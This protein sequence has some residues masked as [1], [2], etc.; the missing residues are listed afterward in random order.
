LDTLSNIQNV[1]GSTYSDILTGD[2]S[3]NIFVG[4][5]GDDTI[6]GG[7]G[8][9]TVDCS[10][11]IAG[12]TV[13]LSG[14]TATDGWGGTDTLTNI[15][16]V[17]GS[18]FDDMITP[19]LFYDNV[20]DGGGG[21]NTV[22]FYY[23]PSGVTVDLHDGTATGAGNDTLINIQNVIG[24]FYDDTFISNSGNHVFDGGAGV[25]T[26]SY[27]YANSG[28]TIDLTAGTATGDGSD[29]LIGIYNATGSSHNDVFVGIS[30][31]DNIIDGGGGIN[32]IDYSHDFAAVTVLL[33]SG[34]AT[35]GF[36]GTDT[37]A[38]IQNI[39]GS[40]YDDYILGDSNDNVIVGGQGNDVID[41]DGGTNTIDYS[42][43]P[44][45]VTVDLS[46]G[47]ATDGWGGSDSLYNFQTIIGSHYDDSI[48][49]DGT[50]TV[51]YETALN[52]VTVDLSMGTA[53]GDGNDTLSGIANVTGSAY[54]DTITGDS[55]DN[56]LYGNGANDYITGG[57]GADTFLFKGA[58]AL[59]GV[60]TIADFNTMDGDKIDITDV[61]QGH[62]DPMTDAITDFVSLATSGSD[63]LLKVDLDGTGGTYIPSTIA[64]IHGV[65]G[66]DVATL[67]GDSNLVVPT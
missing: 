27:A 57:A 39:V 9:N 62:Y 60:T 37:L 17:I 42:H 61:L 15:Q 34:V 20:I 67:I 46:M 25:N 14:G 35:D 48:T 10:H 11:D 54:A 6:D 52:G 24:S 1:I 55:N 8:T 28:V 2:S 29:T 53:T 5:A 64:L 31:V 13:D 58:T 33:S 63:T 38:N 41:G 26:V 19:S 51:S 43:D 44:A 32:T 4:G 40:A 59:T 12:V 22:S 50:S 16:N 49:G 45:G 47:T 30:G 7:G 66:L 23:A 18:A 3:N 36:G 21:I 56:V 65:T